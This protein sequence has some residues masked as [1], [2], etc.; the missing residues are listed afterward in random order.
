[1]QAHVYVQLSV[2]VPCARCG[3]AVRQGPVGVELRYHGILPNSGHRG[4][5]IANGW[6][7]G[8]F[9]WNSQCWGSRAFCAF[10][11]IG[12]TMFGLLCFPQY[13]LTFWCRA[14]MSFTSEAP[15]GSMCWPLLW[16][17]HPSQSVSPS[18]MS[19]QAMRSFPVIAHEAWHQK[20]S[21]H[22]GSK[23]GSC[24]VEENRRAAAER[25]LLH[26]GSKPATV[27]GG[28]V[29]GR[30][31]GTMCVCVCVCVSL[32]RLVFFEWCVCACLQACGGDTVTA[33]KLTCWRNLQS[34][35]WLKRLHS[36]LLN[37]TGS[38]DKT[39]GRPILVPCLQKI[40]AL[41]RA[42]PWGRGP[43]PM[44]PNHQCSWRLPN[45]CWRLLAACCYQAGYGMV[46]WRPG[47]YGQGASGP[48]PL[49]ECCPFLLFDCPHSRHYTSQVNHSCRGATGRG[50]GYAQSVERRNLVQRNSL[51]PQCIQPREKQDFHRKKTE[52]RW[53]R[54]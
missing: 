48:E 4:C 39:E 14:V 44:H 38:K 43:F 19:A 12:V 3:H 37:S 47:R 49:Q 45:R 5:S 13:T 25:S 41:L 1:M 24:M 36:S 51:I 30:V 40:S 20:G 34:P 8:V 53:V 42:A 29:R 46:W 2:R 52:P 15:Q 17:S 54:D 21:V 35:G 23:R 50:G 7:I 28:W 22:K 16:A 26:C 6:P 32:G 18:A 27:Q 11:N 10:E 31:G 33:S 9:G